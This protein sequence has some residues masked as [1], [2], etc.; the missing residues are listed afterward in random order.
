MQ[1]SRAFI[2]PCNPTQTIWQQMIANNYEVDNSRTRHFC[3]LP[4]VK[5]GTLVVHCMVQ[6]ISNFTAFPQPAD[7]RL[8]EFFCRRK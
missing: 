1:L 8:T 6:K 7:F 3:A 2:P 5:I 4:C